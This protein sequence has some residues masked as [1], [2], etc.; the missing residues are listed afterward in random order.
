VHAKFPFVSLWDDHEFAND[1]WAQHATD[2][3]DA[4]RSGSSSSPRASATRAFYEYQAIRRPFTPEAGFPNDLSIQRTLRWGRHADFTLLDERYHRDDHLIPEGVV[5]REVGHFGQNT[6]FGS[7]TFVVK[8]AFDAREAA[9]APTMLG[10]PQRDWA[11]EQVKGSNA[12]WK[13]LCSPLVVA[14][15]VLDL[16]GYTQLPDLLRKRFYF[17]TDQWDGF[18]TERRALLESVKDVENLAVLSGDLHGFY[19][20]TLHADFDAGGEPLA[21][22]YATSAISAPAVD[23]QLEKVIASDA[24]LS[25]LGLGRLVPE[26]DANLLAANPHIQHSVSNRNG[27]AIVEVSAEELRVTFVESTEVTVPVGAVSKET[28]FRTPAGSRVIE[29][30]S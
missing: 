15:M 5:D 27:L 22:E 2:F 1:G 3:D 8:E 6:A 20:A 29:K 7:R 4:R 19:A 11:I 12:T 21:V 26:F 17:K 9:A 10:A 14:Q 16:T 23:V 28:V 18:R 13:L 24:F 25:A 30:V